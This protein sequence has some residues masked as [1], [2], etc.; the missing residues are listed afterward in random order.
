M[1]NYY[2]DEANDSAIEN[3]D[4]NNYRIKNN[5][6]RTSKSFEYKAKLIGTT[7]YNNSKLNAKVVVSLKCL[8]NFWWSLDLS[9]I[10][11]E[12]ELDLTRSKNCVI[13]EI[14]RTPQ[15]RRDNPVDETLRT[16]E[17]FQINNA[18]LYIPAATLSI[19]DNIK[20]LANIMQGF[21]ITISW[22]KYRSVITTQ[23]KNN[24]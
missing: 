6:T 17:I 21:K 7:P 1:W 15:V 5:K 8:S 24:N 18:E 19:N 10:D 11:C 2:R 12:T 9:L 13:S 22:N 3:N 16:G 20:F 4:A 23:T 14:S